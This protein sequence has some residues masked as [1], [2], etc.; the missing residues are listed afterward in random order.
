MKKITGKDGTVRGLKIKQG[1]EFIIQR[2]LQL[3]CDLEIG[4][5]DP[6][7][8]PNPDEE[9]FVPR[10]VPERRAKHIAKDRLRDTFVQE[11]D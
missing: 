3:V 5:E 9:V 10:V 6:K 8:K 2:P 1:N 11:S 4:G 7:W